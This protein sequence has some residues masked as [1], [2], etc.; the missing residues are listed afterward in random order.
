MEVHDLG[1]RVAHGDPGL[2]PGHVFIQGFGET[3][4]EA[5]KQAGILPRH[6][7]DGDP[8]PF[9]APV[10]APAKAT[11]GDVMGTERAVKDAT[12]TAA[13]VLDNLTARL[14]GNAV[15]DAVWEYADSMADP[16]DGPLPHGVTVQQPSRRPS[17]R[18]LVRPFAKPT[19]GLD[20]RDERET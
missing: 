14:G 12:D 13:A 9:D 6:F 15:E 16:L 8:L 1:Y 20:R 19:P 7:K 3:T 11:T 4:I 5:A 10:V 2:R 18:R 17:S